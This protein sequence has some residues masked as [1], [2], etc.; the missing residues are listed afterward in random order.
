MKIKCPGCGLEG[1]IEDKLVLKE[2]KNITCPRCRQKYY[3]VKPTDFYIKGGSYS[4]QP[5]IS[6]NPKLPIDRI[7]QYRRK[8]E[9]GQA[10][11]PTGV[12]KKF[13]D[14]VFYTICFMLAIAYLV[15]SLLAYDSF[16]WDYIKPNE[17]QID[18][19]EFMLSLF[20][21]FS[22]LLLGFLKEGFD[23]GFK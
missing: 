17:F 7:Q 16:V 4:A 19:S 1:K 11:R 18:C 12:L 22:I 8:I 3:I 23:R 14:I 5:D 10:A 13:G 2:G 15:L 20:F 21:I 9:P 6:P